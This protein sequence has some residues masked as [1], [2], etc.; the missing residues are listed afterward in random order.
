[1]KIRNL[2]IAATL[3]LA[4]LVVGSLFFIPI[5]LSG[6]KINGISEKV[7]IELPGTASPDF[8]FE[9]EDVEISF[10]STSHCDKLEKHA[11]YSLVEKFLLTSVKVSYKTLTKL[12]DNRFSLVKL[13]LSSCTFL[14]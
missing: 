14:I 7:H 11:A 2:N 9:I 10:Q 13:F 4:S 1:V 12:N 6:K 3:L 5:F 8:S